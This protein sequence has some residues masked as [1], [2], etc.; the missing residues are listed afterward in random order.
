[1]HART[2]NG[3]TNSWP[4]HLIPVD[5]TTSAAGLLHSGFLHGLPQMLS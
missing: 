3:C 2:A 5:S 1:M 4:H